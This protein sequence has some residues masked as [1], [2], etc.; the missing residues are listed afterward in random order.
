[1]HRHLLHIL[2][3]ILSL[4]FTA[5]MFDWKPRFTPSLD[6]D[7]YLAGLSYYCA[8]L[9]RSFGDI[10]FSRKL[11]PVTTMSPSC[12]EVAVDHQSIDDADMDLDNITN[13]A[14]YFF[15][16]PNVLPDQKIF[17]DA[18]DP[19]H[20][21]T[22]R[23]VEIMVKQ[24]AAG[25]RRE[26]GGKPLDGATVCIHAF[27]NIYYP[28]MFH[29][30][31]A[32][33][34]CFTGTNPAYTVP[35]LEHHFR[36]SKT[37]YVITSSDQS[38]VAVKAA[39]KCKISPPRIFV[40]DE[41]NSCAPSGLRPVVDLFTHGQ[42]PFE[43]FNE[44]RTPGCNRPAAL[45]ATSGTSGLPK[46]AARSHAS[47]LAECMAIVDHKDTPYT[48]RRLICVPMFHAFALPLAMMSALRCGVETYIMPRFLEG[49]F[50]DTIERFGITETAIVPP[51][52]VKL[53]SSISPNVNGASNRSSDAMS[54]ERLGH[55][56]QSLRTI[57]CGGA[58]LSAELQHRAKSTLFHPEARIAQVWG[59]TECGW[60]AT[61]PY[62]ESDITGS[63]GRL[64]PG[65][66]ARVVDP[67]TDISIPQAISAA[68]ATGEICLKVPW[69][70]S[71]YL[72][73]ATATA[74]AFDAEGW[75]RTGDVGHV[76]A[77]SPLPPPPLAFVN[78]ATSFRDDLPFIF[79]KSL[80]LSSTRGGKVY[81]T[82][83]LKDLIKV[84]GWQVSPAELE[85]VL[86]LHPDV[87]DAAV[88]GVSVPVAEIPPIFNTTSSLSSETNGHSNGID[89]SNG[90]WNDRNDQEGEDE[91]GFARVQNESPP[92][93]LVALVRFAGVYPP[94]HGTQYARADAIQEEDGKCTTT[95]L[96]ATTEIPAAYIVLRPDLPNPPTS[97]DIKGFMAQYLAK[98][99]V[100][101]TRIVFVERVP[102]SPS[103]KILRRLL[104]GCVGC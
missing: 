75:Y 25:L 61:F 37:Q 95:T 12:I 79:S 31:L 6:Q 23:E 28:I 68:P 88:V 70:M 66:H 46:V 65:C 24:L 38:G 92:A 60:V 94:G 97:S 49:M 69:A 83:R 11:S 64:L 18:A 86:L 82:D 57:Y 74:S 55:K 1:M 104:G 29:G 16:N 5:N 87:V 34:G 58:P 19:T 35:E 33:G 20:C 50:L 8:Q 71:G 96:L 48:P 91:Q 15:C 14:T 32:A 40:L 77:S 7:D 100:A 13:L 103:G 21:L 43:H 102:K 84:R 22:R 51:I 3:D 36:T 80:K 63:V 73:N 26:N 17:V 67:E 98:Y 81:I 44:G 41:P 30:I 56:L 78:T 52:L 72:N 42:L 10:F 99:K 39:E 27:N 2:L 4:H 89:H 76:V 45:M 85:A 47:L 9:Y 53:L 62:P 101:D 59:M 90:D 93:A 54:T